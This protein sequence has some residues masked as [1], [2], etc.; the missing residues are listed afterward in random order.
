P[1][2]V[3]LPRSFEGR[4]RALEIAQALVHE[5]QVAP[6]AHVIRDAQRHFF[7]AIAGGLGL[8]GFEVA[9]RQIHTR[10]DFL[11]ANTDDLLVDL[12]RARVEP[13]SE[14]DDT[15][16]ALAFDV[17]RLNSQRQLELFF[18]LAD[19]VVLEQLAAAIQVEQEVFTVEL[20]RRRFGIVL[21]S[22]EGGR[23][24]RRRRQAWPPRRRCRSK[25]R[26]MRRNAFDPALRF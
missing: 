2:Q 8:S 23:R 22:T 19:A 13:E 16:Q 24:G 18:R 5:S 21:L 26:P 7:E 14:V 12:L 20:R 6:G 4:A 11:R 3:W 1:H 10:A 25:A 17:L 15:E 9:E